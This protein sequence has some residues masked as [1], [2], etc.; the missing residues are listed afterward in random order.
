MNKI[1]VSIFDSKAQDY[2]HPAIMRSPADAIRSFQTE[3]NTVRDGNM[4]NTNP[5]DFSLHHIADFFPE[6]GEIV[7]NLLNRLLVT[8]S[9]LVS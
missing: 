3:V 2:S 5:E 7:P 4:L 6:S 8:A 9:S 1:L